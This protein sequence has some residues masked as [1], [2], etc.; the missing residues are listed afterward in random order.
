MKTETTLRIHKITSDGALH[1]GSECL[2][3]K[4]VTPKNKITIQETIISPHKT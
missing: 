3:I 2:I 4:T 1:N